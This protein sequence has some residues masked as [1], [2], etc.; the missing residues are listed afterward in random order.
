MTNRESRFNLPPLLKNKNGETRRVGVEIEF[1]FEDAGE[2]AARVA[3]IFKGNREKEND[4]RYRVV[5]TEFGAFTI[6]LDTQYAHPSKTEDGKQWDN[7]LD[8]WLDFEIDKYFHSVIGHMAK[9]LVPY[10]IVT[11][12]I[13]VDRLD[14][15]EPLLE[16]LRAFGAE[17]TDEH[18][19]YA[20]GLHLNPEASAFTAESIL[21]HL[22]AFIALSDWLHAM[23]DID[24][25]RKL[26]PYIQKF[27]TDYALLIM[28]DAYRPDLPSLIDDYLR[29]NPT[30]NRELD[31]LPLFTHLDEAR[32]LNRLQ[33]GL[34]S[35]RPTY[36]YRLPDC[37]LNDPGWS[38]AREWNFWVKV[39]ELAYDREKLEAMSAAY[40]THYAGLT[41]EAAPSTEA[42]TDTTL[43][44]SG[45]SAPDTFFSEAIKQ[46]LPGDW[47]VKVKKWMDK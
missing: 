38:L 44:D 22:R 14:V 47:S 5:G 13:P 21:N 3:R 25:T 30:R 29:H 37:R 32:V 46:I 9:T 24:L 23:M 33:D 7:P 42:G 26:S 15:L 28:P 34:T 36:H 1:A 16:A 45:G 18:P 19:F 40:I 35:A 10:E 8:Q 17:G 31:L 27:P 20:F 39:E 6:E 41:G 43:R 11:P 12:P 2:I 4:H